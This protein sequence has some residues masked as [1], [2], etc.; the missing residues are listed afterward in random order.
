[1]RG[2]SRKEVVPEPGRLGES[3]RKN[4]L[5]EGLSEQTLKKQISSLTS[6]DYRVGLVGKKLCKA[7]GGHLQ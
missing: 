6:V 4:N 2:C 3:T 7:E 5:L 1:M